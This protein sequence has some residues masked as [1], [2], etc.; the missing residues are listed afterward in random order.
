MCKAPTSAFHKCYLTGD[1]SA[2]ATV[3]AA[4][5]SAVS[6]K[7]AAVEAK[8]EVAVAGITLKQRELDAMRAEL[9]ELRKWKE[10]QEC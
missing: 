3:P 8:I 9:S 1:Q 2:A 5:I 6:D 4:V 10:A 7:I